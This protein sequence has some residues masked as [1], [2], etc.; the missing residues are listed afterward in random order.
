MSRRQERRERF[1]GFVEALSNFLYWFGEILPAIVQW[2]V[3][4]FENF[5]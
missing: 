5:S 1:W 3:S 4:I 2:I